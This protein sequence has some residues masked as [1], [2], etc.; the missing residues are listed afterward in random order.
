VKGYKVAK[1]QKQMIL[2]FPH[3]TRDSSEG[4]RI[5]QAINSVDYNPGDF[6][7]KEQVRDICDLGLFRVVINRKLERKS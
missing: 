7:T 2:T 3:I 4:Y 5:E 6:L 1:D